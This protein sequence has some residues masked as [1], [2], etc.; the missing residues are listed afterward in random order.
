VYRYYFNLEGSLEADDDRHGTVLA[1]EEAALA[2]ANRIVRE[3]KEAG[4]YDVTDLKMVVKNSDG[5][6]I[7]V[8]PF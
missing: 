2:Y 7:Y 4:G 3:L 6:V 5:N 8:I 1:S